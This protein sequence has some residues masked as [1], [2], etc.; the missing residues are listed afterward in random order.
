MNKEIEKMASI[1]VNDCTTP[2]HRC[3]YASDCAVLEDAI[4]LY[5]QSYRKQGEE[6]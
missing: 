1:L 3:R 5:K 6:K 2:C 4:K